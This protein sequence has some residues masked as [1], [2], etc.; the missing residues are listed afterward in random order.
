[1]KKFYLLLALFVGLCSVSHGQQ[2]TSAEYFFDSDPGIGNATPVSIGTPSD[3][4]DVQLNIS[5]AGLNPGVHFFCLRTQNASGNWSLH[6]SRLF[7]VNPVP[8]AVNQQ[9]AQAEYFFD[10]DPGIGNGSPVSIGSSS[11]TVLTTININTTGLLPGFHFFCLRT[12]NTQGQWSLQHSRLFYINPLPASL[13]QQVIDGEYF[14]DTDPGI[15]NG[16]PVSFTA[17]DTIDTS[18]PVINPLSVGSHKFVLRTRDADGNWSLHMA[19][20]FNVCAT[21]GPK[22]IFDYVIDFNKVYFTNNSIYT[23]WYKW[24]FGDS[25]SDTVL[26]SPSHIYNLPGIYNAKLITYNPCA[27]DT[28]IKTIQINGITSAIPK[29]ATPSG[30]FMMEIAGYGFTASSQFKLWRPGFPDITPDSAKVGVSGNYARLYYRLDSAYTGWWHLVVSGTSIQDTLFG[31]LQIDTSTVEGGLELGLNVPTTVRRFTTNT[32]QVL[33]KNTGNRPVFGVPVYISNTKNGSTT[34]LSVGN[35][36][37]DSFLDTSIVNAGPPGR[38]YQNI[39]SVTGDTSGHITSF[40]IPYLAAGESHIITLAYKTVEYGTDYISVVVKQPMIADETILA[41]IGLRQP[42]SN[43]TWMPPCMQATLDAAGLIPGVG[44]A[45]GIF[46]LACALGNYASDFDEGNPTGKSLMD[47]GLASTSTLLSCMTGLPW[48]KLLKLLNT[49]SKAGHNN[50][51]NTQSSYSLCWDDIT[52]DSDTKGVTALDP[53]DKTGPNG[54]AT[55]NFIKDKAPLPYTIR[56]ENV[57]TASAPAAEVVITDTLDITRFDV[58]TFKYSM[59]GWADSNIVLNVPAAN[60]AREFDLRP[61]KNTIL[62][63]IGSIDTATGIATTR[64]TSYDPDT[65]SIVINPADGFL[66]PN[67]NAPEGEGFVS[68]YCSLLPGLNNMDV[69]DNKAEI[70]FDLEAPVITPLFSNTLDLEKPAS[71]VQPISATSDT[72]FTVRWNGSDNESGVK[73]YHVYV[74]ENDSAYQLWQVRTPLDSGVFT[75]AVGSTYK[76][77]SVAVDSVNNEE[78]APANPISNP[79]AVTMVVVGIAEAEAAEE[80]FSVYPNPS[81]E[82]VTILIHTHREKEIEVKLVD[83]RGMTAGSWT[84]KSNQK[85]NISLEN[86]SPGIYHFEAMRDD[87][88]IFIKKITVL[89]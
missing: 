35:P 74:S 34:S 5:V 29:I 61:G 39:D 15:G 2:I 66:N 21:Y 88:R 62:R 86:I 76:F 79:D 42:M 78:D 3:T 26:Y 67:V 13:N 64:F 56:F 32:F 9:V 30:F 68:F 4:I 8:L 24:D 59:F 41:I 82:D 63:V 20:A 14:F 48:A 85:K 73:H 60:F 1:M 27:S 69:I 36:F 43:C 47:L 17:S 28:L 81:A 65:F 77:Y 80:F 75:G 10:N 54:Y 83:V 71:S 53:N 38:F 6:H 87:R 31:A 44:C 89:K 33:I 45:V 16:I 84:I 55:P 25:Q 22:S 7:Y 57:D 23:D 51:N 19:K 49:G 70:V 46:D 50:I 72:T 18:F 40:M 52:A 11:D 58:S 12:Q 37:F